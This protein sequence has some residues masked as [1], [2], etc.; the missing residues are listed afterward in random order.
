MSV[1]EFD[2]DDKRLILQSLLA[3][4]DID[5]VTV[6][7]NAGFASTLRR[8]KLMHFAYLQLDVVCHILSF[9]NLTDSFRVSSVCKRWHQAFLTPRFWYG[10]ITDWIL[11]YLA[12]NVDNKIDHSLI[13]IFAR[14]NF[15][16]HLETLKEQTSWLFKKNGA[17]FYVSKNNKYIMRRLKSSK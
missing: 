7:C 14:A 9:T 3:R 6:L 12:A 10:R 5:V 13:P 8:I 17:L 2:D 1:E 16:C 11:K 15:K 4:P